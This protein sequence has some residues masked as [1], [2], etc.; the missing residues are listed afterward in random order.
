MSLLLFYPTPV[1]EKEDAMSEDF[2][3]KLEKWIIDYSNTNEESK[4]WSK[5]YYGAGFTSFSND[6]KLH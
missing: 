4:N 3:Q 2:N 5:Q 1:F 6:Q